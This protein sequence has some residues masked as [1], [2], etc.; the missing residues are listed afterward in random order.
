VWR[1][2]NTS[3]SNQLDEEQ[4]AELDEYS[5]TENDYGYNI[6]IARKVGWASAIFLGLSMLFLI[7]WPSWITFVILTISCALL[8][9]GF[10]FSRSERELKK[11]NMKLEEV[12]EEV[13][14]EEEERTAICREC[15]QEVSSKASRCPHCGWKPK[16]RG[17]LYWTGTTFLSFTP[18]GWI[19]AAK[20]AKDEIE[21]ER[22]M[23]KKVGELSEGSDPTPVDKEK[24]PEESSTQ[25]EKIQELN[26]LKQQGIISEDE[27][28]AKKNELLDEL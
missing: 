25:V 20:G 4:L 1:Q 2:Y 21:G 12:V 14:I 16:K 28:E 27:F 22:G 10:I 24:N 5:E 13:E 11:I 8:L 7:A 19:F 6:N 26:E 18:V 17:M 23:S 3:V 9:F 15:K